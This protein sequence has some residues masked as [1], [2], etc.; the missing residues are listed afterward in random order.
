MIKPLLDRALVVLVQPLAARPQ[1]QALV[2]L[3]QALEAQA[4][5]RCTLH[6][7]L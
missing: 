2:A 1:E 4:S 6:V 3:G 5:W 7:L